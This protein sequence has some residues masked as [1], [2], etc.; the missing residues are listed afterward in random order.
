MVL[1]G[2]TQEC[3]HLGLV[4]M[5]PFRPHLGYPERANIY[6]KSVHPT[7]SLGP[8]GERGFQGDGGL[9]GVDPTSTSDDAF[10]TPTARREP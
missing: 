7:P 3:S 5:Y 8:S 6:G 10:A 1:G 2:P 4:P 9:Q